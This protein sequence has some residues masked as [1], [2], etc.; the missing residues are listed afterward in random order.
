MSK[1]PK[2]QAKFDD[3]SSLLPVDVDLYVCVAITKNGSNV[4]DLYRLQLSKD[5][6]S[7]FASSCFKYVEGINNDI[8]NSSKIL[9][10]YDASTPTDSHEIEIDVYQKG[11]TQ[12]QVEIALGQASVIPI[13]K[14]PSDVKGKMQFYS[15]TLIDKSNNNNIYHFFRRYSNSKNLAKSLKIHA[16]FDKGSFDVIKEPIFVFDDVY[17]AII[18]DGEASIFKKDNYHALFKYFDQLKVNATAT[19]S[20]ITNKV[21]IINA[22]LFESDS[23][24]N[25]LILI[26]LRSI[27]S[28]PYLPVI[29]IDD[30]EK[31]IVSLNLPIAVSNV[32]GVKSIVY[33]PKYKWKLI[34][35]LDDAFLS[36]DMTGE[37][38]E[39]IGKRK[40]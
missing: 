14:G 29:T 40:I 11:T 18:I 24:K 17:D 31:K 1:F 4:P 9:E 25:P 8:K 20:A 38:Y 12:D 19:I 30:L 15:I 36:S 5:L 23:K 27:Y 37:N 10:P 2:F 39:T 13:Y 7:Q 28:K 22:L 32:G 21:P 16:M 6:A 26:K 33:D 3:L 35:L 34:R